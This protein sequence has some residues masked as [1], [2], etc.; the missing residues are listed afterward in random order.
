MNL[1]AN[2]I[3][4]HVTC[5]I[6]FTCIYWYL[7]DHFEGHSKHKIT[8]IDYILLATTIQ[9]G[10]GISYFYPVSFWGK[11]TMMIQQF[12][13]IVVNVFALTSLNFYI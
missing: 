9:A 6:I 4:F 13:M 2:I 1:I 7:K 11:L 3:S 10:I 8:S 5:I 12:I